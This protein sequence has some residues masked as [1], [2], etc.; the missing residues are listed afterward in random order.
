MAFDACGESAAGKDLHVFGWLPGE[1]T[2]VRTRL[3]WH[4]RAVVGLLF[5]SGG[6]AE[7]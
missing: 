3:R 4:G 2:S 6:D 7:E 1:A 5:G